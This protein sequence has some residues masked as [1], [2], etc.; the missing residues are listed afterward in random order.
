MYQFNYVKAKSLQE[1]VKLLAKNAEAK[2]LA[3]GMTLL[4]TLKQRLARPTHLIDIAGLPE[5]RKIEVKGGKLVIGAGTRHHDVAT[6]PVVKK[7]IPALANLASAIGDP[8]VRNRGT[9]AGSLVHADPAAVGIR[10]R[11]FERRLVDGL[12][13]V[14]RDLGDKAIG[15][16][17][18]AI[19][20]SGAGEHAAARNESP[21]EENTIE[22]PGPVCPEFVGGF[23]GGQT[24][25]NPDEDVFGPLFDG[26]A[27][28]VLDVVFLAIDAGGELVSAEVIG[29]AGKRTGVHTGGKSAVEFIIDGRP[30]FA[31]TLDRLSFVREHFVQHHGRCSL[32]S[33]D[34]R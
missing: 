4:P 30:L 25:G 5:L 21:V 20:I 17:L 31:D 26:L 32:F 9:L 24:C 11:A 3:G 23:G 28:E 27:G 1:A 34:N 16:C 33:L 12:D 2:L 10:A 15:E 29:V 18:E 8:Q 6:S 19:K 13:V 14:F 7:A 22:L